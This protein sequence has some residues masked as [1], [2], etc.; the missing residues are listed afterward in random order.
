VSGW[1]PARRTVTIGDPLRKNP[2]AESGSYSLPF[3]KF[4]NA[5]M[6]GILTYDENLLV[7]WKK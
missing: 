2:I 1:D 7:I 5:V 3:T 4:S 6:L